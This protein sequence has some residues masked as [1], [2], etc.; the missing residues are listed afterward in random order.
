MRP[1]LKPTILFSSIS[2][3]YESYLKD[4][5]WGCFHYIGIP[6]DILDKMPIR[7][8]KFYIRKHNNA[9]ENNNKA[10]NPKGVGRTNDPNMINAV[11]Q[12][13]QSANKNTKSLGL[14]L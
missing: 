14:Q 4:E 12:R 8:R 5:L 1:F 7:D 3:N 13:T 11:A 10:V 6:L 9:A 2:P